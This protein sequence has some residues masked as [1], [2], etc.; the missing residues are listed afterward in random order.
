MTAIKYSKQRAAILT[1]LSG[2]K[3]HP[4]ADT[5]YD[6]LRKDFPNISLGTVYR[7]LNLLADLGQIMKITTESGGV[8]FDYNTSSHYHIVCTRC[9]AVKDLDLDPKI[10]ETFIHKVQDSYEGE[11][12]T[13][14]I[15]FYGT[16]KE[17]HKE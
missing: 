6:N 4:T 5:V 16:C 8:R 12:D 9:G 7:N 14:S 13:H 3:E 1:Y 15:L 11:I 17:C 2:T 10:T